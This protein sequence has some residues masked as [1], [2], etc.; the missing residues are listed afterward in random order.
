[1][2]TS[3]CVLKW[4]LSRHLMLLPISLSYFFKIFQLLTLYKYKTLQK[5]FKSD[6]HLCFLYAQ[7][8]PCITFC[9]TII[10][11]CGFCLSFWMSLCLIL[12][13]EINLNKCSTVCDSVS[14]NK[15]LS[16]LIGSELYSV[17]VSVSSPSHFWVWYSCPCQ[18]HD[19][20][21]H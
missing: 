20:K 12:S 16:G 11:L 8:V 17:L 21:W 18:N 4:S 1:M 13:I 10:K 15:S 19:P 9:H 5:Y 14:A 3:P 2:T 6:V 7:F